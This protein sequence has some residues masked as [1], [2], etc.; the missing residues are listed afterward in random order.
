MLDVILVVYVSLLGLIIGSAINAIVWRL[1]E[2]KS[3]VHGRSQCPKCGHMLA[4]VDLI[5]VLSWVWLRGRCRYCNKPISVKYPLVELLSA[6]VFGLSVSALPLSTPL[7][8]WT[9]ALWLL[10][11]TLLLVLA[12][13]D[14]KWML[15]PDKIIIPLGVVGALF[16]LSAVVPAS[17]WG[18]ASSFLLG[19]LVSGGFFYAIAAFSRGRAMG[20]G[21]IKLAFVMG[22][23]LNPARLVVAMEIA[24][25]TASIIGVGM[26]AAGRIERRGHLPFGPYLVL[27]AIVS[28]LYGDYIINLYLKI[29]GLN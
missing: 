2:G 6:L 15:L 25:V 10:I 1:H 17:G 13:Y 9:I 14:L 18:T 21:D 23:F 4:A 19:A 8:Q 5:P 24:F 16:V 22:L 26:L 7:Q 28:F 29:S 11:L 3:W 20:G 27:G 12:V